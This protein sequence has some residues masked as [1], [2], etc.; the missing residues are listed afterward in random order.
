MRPTIGERWPLRVS[1]HWMLIRANC[2]TARFLSWTRESLPRRTLWSREFPSAR[3]SPHRGRET[4]YTADSRPAAI[5][6]RHFLATDGTSLTADTR[7]DRRTSRLSM[8]NPDVAMKSSNTRQIGEPFTSPSPQ[9][10]RVRGAT[11]RNATLSHRTSS[12]RSVSPFSEPSFHWR[13]IHTRRHPPA[14]GG[15]ICPLFPNCG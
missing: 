6:P 8:I 11:R 10:H 3:T 12:R 7:S 5:G 9:F 2:T 13:L 1:L 15:R 4:R 14:G